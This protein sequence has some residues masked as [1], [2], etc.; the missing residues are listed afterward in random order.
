MIAWW[1]E[2]CCLVP[3]IIPD[4]A[5][6]ACRKGCDAVR[7]ERSKDARSLKGAWGGGVAVVISLTCCHLEEILVVL[8]YAQLHERFQPENRTARQNN[9]ILVTVVHETPP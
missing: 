4:A 2:F 7:K 3:F 8:W 5:V 6:D 1:C 9:D